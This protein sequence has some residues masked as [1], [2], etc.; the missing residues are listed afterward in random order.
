MI[1]IIRKIKNEVYIFIKSKI[2]YLFWILPIDKKKIVFANNSAHLS[3]ALQAIYD[4]LIRRGY[5]R[6]KIVILTNKKCESNFDTTLRYGSIRSIIE[7]STAK[8]WISDSRQQAYFKKRSEQVYIM[9]WHGSEP[10]KY[11]EKD[12]ETTLP[13]EYIR[14]AINDSKNADIMVAQS[15][16]IYEIM[17]NSFWYDGLILQECFPKEFNELTGNYREEIC[18]VFNI[19]FNCAIVL[20]VP[21]FRKDDEASYYKINYNNL[22]NG[23]KEKTGRSFK[24]IVRLHENA[25]H[26]INKIEYNENVINGSMYNSVEKLISAADYVI[27]DYS[28][29]LF[30]AYYANKK[31]IVYAPD[32]DEYIKNDRGSYF[33]FSK[34][35]S[36]IVKMENELMDSLLDYN[37]EEFETGR[38]EFLKR[39]GYYGGDAAF[40][41]V[42]IITK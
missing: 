20:Y 38:K 18:N 16:H 6:N 5:P 41:I 22:A 11:I 10:I 24:I 4:E 3:G 23:L 21:T 9:T 14:C 42:D 17:K 37:P 34:M 7:L 12:A 2:F 19:D 36:P 35:P 28:S 30:K 8:Y 39:L 33:D 26:N 27:T 1:S 40:S 29:C 31:A 25:S 15:K 32:L 13:K